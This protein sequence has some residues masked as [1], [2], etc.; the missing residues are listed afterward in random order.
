[1]WGP[2]TNRAPR[3]SERSRSVGI[4]VDWVWGGDSLTRV[5]TPKWIMHRGL[6]ARTALFWKDK[7]SAS[8]FWY[9]VRH[10]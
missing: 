8:A 5:R 1:M 2:T 9:R 10:G 7:R 6:V 3:S 4:W